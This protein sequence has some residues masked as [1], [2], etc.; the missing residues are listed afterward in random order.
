MTGFKTPTT[1][2][3]VPVALFI[4]SYQRSLPLNALVRRSGDFGLNVA[5]GP[6]LEMVAQPRLGAVPRVAFHTSATTAVGPDLPARFLLFKTTGI[7]ELSGFRFYCRGRLVL[8][9]GRLGCH[10]QGQLARREGAGWGNKGGYD[11]SGAV[12]LACHGVG[13][14][15]YV[16]RKT[17]TAIFMSTS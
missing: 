6:A 11:H 7:M 12:L 16:C 2:R 10:R 8:G 14:L 13:T 17:R 1:L 3:S 5:E 4:I 15:A 9:L